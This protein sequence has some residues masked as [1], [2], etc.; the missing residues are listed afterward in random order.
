MGYDMKQ[1]VKDRNAA[2]TAFVM[3]DDWNAIIEYCRTYGVRM[4]DNDKVFAAGVY[5]AVQEVKNIPDDV[6]QAAAVKCLKLG[7]SPFM[8]PYE[9]KEEQHGK[10]EIPADREVQP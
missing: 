2:F 4:P 7:M 6:K 10:S 1:F 5:K 9:P 3:N 8:R